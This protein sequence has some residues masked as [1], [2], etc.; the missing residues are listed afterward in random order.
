MREERAPEPLSDSEARLAVA[1]ALLHD[2]VLVPKHHPDRSRA[3]ERSAG[4]ARERLAALGFQ[5]GG[6]ERVAAAIRDHSFSRGA[7]PA[8]DLGRALQDAD[9]LEALGAIGLFRAIAT[10][11]AMGAGF[12]HADDPWALARELDDRAWSTD[13]FFRKL[14]RLP[15]TMTTRGGRIE[16]ERRAGI[17]RAFVREL[18]EELG[19]ALPESRLR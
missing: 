7:T 5:P 11:A 18:A 6:I 14:L 8:D 16:A 19:V 3:S 15:A 10:G 9:R 2:A 1:A 13:H 17:L 4:H 12:F